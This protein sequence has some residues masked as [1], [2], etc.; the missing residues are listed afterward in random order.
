LSAL[1]FG[2]EPGG[3]KKGFFSIW[4]QKKSGWRRLKAKGVFSQFLRLYREDGRGK[5]ERYHTSI[6]SRR[7]RDTFGGGRHYHP[8]TNGFLLAEKGV[9]ERGG[10]KTALQEFER[11]NG[12]R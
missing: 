11:E 12:L 3:K 8:C 4:V 2:S 9:A 10:R 1:A 5:K 7:E 6:L